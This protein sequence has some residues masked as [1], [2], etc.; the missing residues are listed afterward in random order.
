MINKKLRRCAAALLSVCVLFSI[1]TTA[2]AWFENNWPLMH[3][4]SDISIRMDP[5][6]VD[7]QTAKTKG[8]ALN[9]LLVIERAE[10]TYTFAPESGTLANS[11]TS[12]DYTNPVSHTIV[13]KNGMSAPTF[14]IASS[15][16]YSTQADIPERIKLVHDLVEHFR[17]M[18]Q[19]EEKIKAA[20]EARIVHVGS[21]HPAD[22]L[23]LNTYINN[24]SYPITGHAQLDSYIDFNDPTVE[25][26]IKEIIKQKI[27]TTPNL[28]PEQFRKI[29]NE[30]IPWYL[31][32]VENHRIQEP[33]ILSF[34]VGSSKG[35]VDAEKHTVT[36]RMPIGYDWSKAPQP[37]IQTPVGV[38][39]NHG[40]GDLQN[41][42]AA[43]GVVPFDEATG[44]IYDGVDGPWEN[45]YDG[46]A[47]LSQT[48]T[49]FVE[50][51]DPYNMVTS[52]AIVTA[53]GVKRYAEIDETAKTITLNL[54]R[55]TDLTA[56]TPELEHTGSSTTMDSNAV[57]F[58]NPQT[59]TVSNPEFN[60]TT[61]YAVTVTALDSAENDILSYKIGDAVGT[62]SQTN[63]SITV[64]YGTNLTKAEPIT[65]ISEFATLEKPAA[66]KTN[67]PLT[68]TVTAQSGAKKIYTVTIHETQA[69]YGT[70]ITSFK[71]SSL[72][73]NIDD[74]NGTI[75]LSV[76]AGTNVKSLI[77]TI[78]LS[79][80]ATVSPASGV[81]QNF[82]NP[83]VYTVTSQAGN[84]AIYTV[85]VTVKAS[86]TNPYKTQ[87]TTLLNKII[88][89]YETSASDDWEWMNLGFYQKTVRNTVADLPAN[90]NLYQ[91]IKELKYL[92][93]NAM[94]ELDRAI[95][96]MTALGINTS[97]LEAYQNNAA[98]PFL[99]DNGETVT[100]LVEKLYNYQGSYTINGPI[101]ALNALNMGNYTL[102][103]NTYWNKEKLLEELLNH[104]YGSDGFDID[105]VGMLMQAISPY[106]NDPAYGS[107]V[108]AKLDEGVEII[109]GNKKVNRVTP[110]NKDFTF[111]SWG[112]TNS[113]SADQVI[114]ALCACGIDPHTD[115][116][117][118]D[119]NGNSVITKWLDFAGEDSFAHT[120]S[121]PNN[122]MATYQGC[123]TLQWYL[124][125]LEHGGA[126]HP[127]SLYYNRFDFKTPLSR[128]A[129]ILSFTLEGK[130][131]II[132]ET[133]K[134]IKVT[135]PEGMPLANM[136]P[137]LSF[138]SK[139]TLLAPKLPVTFVADV[140]QPFTVLAEDGST[141][142]TYN[143]TV[144]LSKD[145]E[146]SGTELKPETIKLMSTLQYDLEILDKQITVAEDGA[147]E[148]VL[149]V[150]AGAKPQAMRMK[151]ELS[152]GAVSDPVLD[153]KKDLD[154]S[155]WLTVT[156]TSQEGQPITKALPTTRVYRIKAVNEK[157][158]AIE[159]F[160][161]TIN[162]KLYTGAVGANTVSI[163]DVPS[164]ANV[165]SLAPDI[166]LAAGTNVCA[167]ASGVPQD[168]TNPV[169]YTVSGDGLKP[170][171]YTVTVT[172]NGKPDGGDT[173][174]DTRALITAFSIDS[175]A[176][177]IDNAAGTIQVKLPSDTDMTKL[178]PDVT[179]AAGCT[180]DP[181]QGEV[182]NF[183]EPVVYTVTRGDQSKCYTVTVVLKR[184][185]ADQL[186]D[187]VAKNNTV[188]SHQESRDKS[189]LS[190]KR[191]R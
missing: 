125:F 104:E 36:L 27:E 106:Q 129:N 141:K 163:I 80:F 74:G 175:V 98:D 2:V 137:K 151:A 160:V 50:K 112:A 119:G 122:A 153:G 52:F 174:T 111:G 1:A 178:C 136:M 72:T 15:G 70:K 183:E 78:E 51:G 9:G 126:E 124:N 190:R 82:T 128:E 62:I 145:V 142:K 46:G 31:N 87:M 131:G 95:M 94:T 53:D 164:D 189:I 73:A 54:P 162:K 17:K 180:I 45:G 157:V 12:A 107:R 71:Y 38:K 49:V 118:S 84:S 30:V 11:G 37:V 16:G 91:I 88:A 86:T 60:L 75:S 8:I 168:F 191:K 185:A 32:Y 117:F 58:T 57:N 55:G 105:M 33:K 144:T 44:I 161:L 171:A 101:F 170:K 152:Y 68:Y 186:W 10:G 7:G 20:F 63:I 79:P 120:D 140:P 25:D 90:L 85:T 6:T 41:G 42:K 28:T 172:K 156:V 150:G 77:P 3:Y 132:N 110:M 188:V 154:L 47:N 181:L 96:M 159:S 14:F 40:A 148:I 48:W 167:P 67:I 66:L 99:L 134:T 59:L 166:T 109:L 23:R 130:E 97:N 19:L 24:L 146:G 5:V 176:G 147:T 39:S 92:G 35:L 116:R 69:A 139:A 184:S 155:N 165:T 76:P 81:A 56:L 149:I 34:S 89:R 22:W 61:N 43:Y 138:S 13:N 4:K 108:K 182:L 123:Y 127:Y 177:N 179:V 115:P 65:K 143:L 121:T 29:I 100:N 133:D 135:L 64:P 113:E 102:P 18:H 26:Q 93:A 21:Y 158:A 173:P 83:V 169:T 187:K 103:D 114:C